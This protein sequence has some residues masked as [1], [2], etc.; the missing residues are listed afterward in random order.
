MTARFPIS[1]IYSYYGAFAHRAGFSD[2]L[3]RNRRYTGS[4]HVPHV[5]YFLCYG[6]PP[7]F[8]IMYGV[9]LPSAH[10]SMRL[11]HTHPFPV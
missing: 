7:L 3:G 8:F 9:L 4:P 5:G 6:Y 2:K 11:H 10:V 1:C